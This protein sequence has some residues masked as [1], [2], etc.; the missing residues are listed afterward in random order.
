MKKYLLIL[1]F[2]LT[3]ATMLSG[4]DTSDNNNSNESNEITI[5]ILSGNPF[6][7]TAAERFEA[8]Y[9]GQYT[10][11]I[12]IYDDRASYAQIINTALMSGMGE[13]I[14]HAS[15]IPWERL[16]D[17]NNLADLNSILNFAPGEFYQ[18][19]LDAF[20][21]NGRRH[22]IPLSFHMETF[23]TADAAPLNIYPNRF[24]LNDL[25]NLANTYPDAHLII[26]PAG[27]SEVNIA[28]RFFNLS[29]AEFIDLPNRQANVDTDKF[30][31]LLEDV[32]SIGDRLRAPFQLENVLIQEDIF[33]NPAMASSGMPDYT[34]FHIMTNDRGEGMVHAFDLLAINANSTNQALA[35]RFLQF[36]ISEE[37]QTS[38]EIWQTA[39]NR[40]AAISNAA[41]LYESIKAGDFA[42]PEYFNLSTNIAVFNR[43]AD[44]LTIA[45]TSDPFINEFVRNEMTRFF[46]G[47]VTAE[48]AARNLQARLTTYLNE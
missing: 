33:F 22:V 37:M 45:P 38:P 17:T 16:A 12:T 3:S 13:D 29:F 11:N 24:A 4:C 26:G 5:A 8:M 40:H 43:L 46:D 15:N 47:E 10:I 1:V 20:L 2:V 18:T 25:I 48:Q 34:N 35:A 7:E 21:Y 32:Q 27:T 42:P 23:S 14:I 19:I 9:D 39:V 6:I 31:R 28:H 36:L 44:R 41:A 30:I